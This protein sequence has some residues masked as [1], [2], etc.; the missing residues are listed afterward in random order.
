[1]LRR[2]QR[3]I[4]FERQWWI[5]YIPKKRNII[6][7]RLAKLSFVCKSSLKVFNVTLNEILEVLQQDKTSVVFEQLI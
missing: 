5:K 3:I 7:S 6:T 1:M 4:R 2:V